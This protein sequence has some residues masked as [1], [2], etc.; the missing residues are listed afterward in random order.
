MV[1]SWEWAELLRLVVTFAV[2]FA[3][4]ALALRRATRVP[5]TEPV[6]EVHIEEEVLS[7]VHT[8]EVPSPIQSEV[9]ACDVGEFSPTQE[10]LEE[11]SARW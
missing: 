2:G 10:E 5:L 7:P 6:V 1:F 9:W 3:L 11:W 8:E 4:G